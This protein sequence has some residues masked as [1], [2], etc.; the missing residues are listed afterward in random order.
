M[1]VSS[2]QKDQSERKHDHLLS[3][4][5]RVE[6]CG[7]GCPHW[8]EEIEKESTDADVREISR[9]GG[10]D[11]V[12][13]EACSLIGNS[14]SDRQPV[15]MS[16]YWSGVNMWRCTDYKTGCTTSFNGAWLLHTLNRLSTV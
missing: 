4:T 11:G 12:E 9:G 16:E 2:R 7:G 10:G 8:S 3:C 6:F 1:A 13:T 5:Y 15:Q 14:G